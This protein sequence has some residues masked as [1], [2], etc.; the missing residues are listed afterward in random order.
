MF[1]LHKTIF[2][3]DIVQENHSVMNDVKHWCHLSMPL[4]SYT[5]YVE[6]RSVYSVVCTKTTRRLP[7]EHAHNGDHFAHRECNTA[8]L[9]NVDVPQ[10]WNVQN[11]GKPSFGELFEKC[12]IGRKRF[13]FFCKRC[14]NFIS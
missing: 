11:F 9:P 1:H 12:Q 10:C 8:V 4:F 2:R 14:S 13:F 7:I 6:H 3:Y 5:L